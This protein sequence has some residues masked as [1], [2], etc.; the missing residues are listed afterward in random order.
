MVVTLYHFVW[1]TGSHFWMSLQWVSIPRRTHVGTLLEVSFTE[2]PWES[3]ESD[4]H[5]LLG[6]EGMLGFQGIYRVWVDLCEDFIIGTHLHCSCILTCTDWLH[7]YSTFT[8]HWES[9]SVTLESW[10]WISWDVKYECIPANISFFSLGDMNFSCIM[11]WS[12]MS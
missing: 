11:T 10:V 8:V 4:R 3:Q 7:C 1:S 2:M 12:Y 9:R 6:F 5:A